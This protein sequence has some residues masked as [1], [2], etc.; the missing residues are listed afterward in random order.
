MTEMMK[1]LFTILLAAFLLV[2][3]ADAQIF[4]YG[5]KAGIG[6]SS[7]KFNDIT[8]INDG[9][10]VY[11]LVTGD[12]VMGYHLGVQT[13]VKLAM[14]YVQPEIYFNTGGGTVEQVITGG[15]TA[16]LDVKFSRLDVPVLVGVKLG[17]ARF[18][19]GPVG[20]FVLSETN[21]L[22]TLVPGYKVFSQS[23]TWGFQA[24]FGVDLLKKISLDARYEGSLSRL[25]ETLTIGGAEFPL[26]ARPRQW[27][28]SLG[29]WF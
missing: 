4:S 8:G 7:L 6:F 28:I 22:Q 11:D 18:N 21:D 13:R 15:A 23:M 19:L 5:V 16:I 3:V 25:G 27:L 12:A 26:D 1:K 20:S 29:I 9:S 24:G 17:P 2:Q 10:Q 14:A